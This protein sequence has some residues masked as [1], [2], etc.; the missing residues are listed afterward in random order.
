MSLFVPRFL[1]YLTIFFLLTILSSQ[2]LERVGLGNLSRTPFCSFGK[3]APISL[4]EFEPNRG[5]ICAVMFRSV[6]VSFASSVA[7]KRTC[8]T[9]GLGTRAQTFLYLFV[10]LGSKVSCAD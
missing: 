6:A 10:F 7:P 3:S 5:H 1:F 9:T 2:E 4:A 8:P